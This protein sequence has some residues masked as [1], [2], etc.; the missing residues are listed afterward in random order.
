MKQN[1]VLRNLIV[2]LCGATLA[3]IA[4]PNHVCAA[5]KTA[6][7]DREKAITNL[8]AHMTVEEKVLQLQARDPNGA[9]RLGV[10][11]L[12]VGEALHGVVCPGATAF[13]QAI[14]LGSTWSPDL[15]E[16]VAGVIAKESRAVGIQ[17]VFA[18]MLGLAQDAR[19]GR[20]EES[21][22]EDPFLVSRIGVAYINGLQGRGSERFDRNHVIATAKHFAAD[23][24]P[25]TGQN[26]GS[27]EI[28]EHLLRETF[29]MPFEAAV[30]EARVGAIMPAHHAIN[31]VPCHGNAWLLDDVLRKEWGFDGFIVSDFGDIYNLSDNPEII[32]QHVVATP[33]AAARLALECGVDME[34]APGTW[35]DPKRV[36]AKTLLDEV[37]A[38]RVPMA[39]VDRA[40]GR[41]LR[42]KLTLQGLRAAPGANRVAVT[43]E[44][45]LSQPDVDDGAGDL[46]GRLV[47]DGQ[48]SGS[49]EGGRAD[50]EKVL[51]DPA[52]DA[53][54]LK[55]AQ[56]AIVLLKNQGDLLPLQ[57]GKIKSIAVVGP[58]AT[59]VTLGGYSTPK[60]KFYVNVV[61]GL[62]AQFGG[63]A[64]ITFAPGCEL[65][66]ESSA[67]LPAAV[68]AASAA[69]VVVCVVGSTRKQM[70]ENLD[71]DNLDLVGGQKK[72]VESVHATGKPVVVVLLN[73]GPIS[74]PWIKKNIPAIVEGWYLGQAT[75]TALAQVLTGEV[76]PGGKL[77]VT[78]PQNVGRVPAY[79]Y[80]PPAA[81]R[82]NYYQSPGG[83]LFPFGYGLSYTKFAYSDLK[84]SPGK[85]SVNQ[86]ATVS[87]KLTNTGARAGDEVVQLYLHD[88]VS[89]L[90]RPAKELRGF[91]RVT[92]AP[93]ESREVKFPVGFEHLKFWKNGGWVVEP[94]TFT[95]MIGSSSEDIRLKGQLEIIAPR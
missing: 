10:P 12:H 72:L 15:I 83:D 1:E 59:N 80:R 2:L 67:L 43:A 61:E 68:E 29:L 19:W 22:G 50:A 58:L 73:G 34:L 47:R 4:V 75:G 54:A 42:A 32:S 13:P 35:D 78:I 64:K 36:Y 46:W 62:K 66:N 11:N 24:L 6:V 56:E 79:Y 55:A 76:N 20:V 33:A 39:L 8:L 31:G 82:M 69:D 89:S 52:H 94:G 88:D 85:F 77:P 57:K 7:A 92:L 44:N 51:N 38:G 60:P 49:G 71:R 53:L 90:V 21:Y 63:A 23:G 25:L 26:G 3:M 40:A 48:L 14:A 81:R 17:Q 70:G 93:G 41:V 30:K 37:Q 65:E 84:I 27:I 91:E 28:S 87:L 86:T 9:P 18:P 45:R 95:V 74:I 5:D 16:Q